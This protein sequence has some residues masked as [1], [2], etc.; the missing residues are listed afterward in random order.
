MFIV[1]KCATSYIN[2]PFTGSLITKDGF[3]G[4]V[5]FIDFLIVLSMVVFAVVLEK[6]QKE[7]VKTFKNQTIE[8][9]DFTIMVRRLPFDKEY[10]GN[11]EH[12][13]IYLIAHF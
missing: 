10:G 1:A 11:P 4:V 5:V 6:S 13:K 9:T 3:A 7:Y 8:M 12:L 2:N